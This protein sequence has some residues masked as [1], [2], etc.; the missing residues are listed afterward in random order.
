[1]R[2]QHGSQR[3][4]AR[5]D[6]LGILFHLVLEGISRGE[7]RGVGGKG[8]RDLAI[9]LGEQGALLGERIHVG[10]ADAGIP[11]GAQ[12]V[13]AERVNRYK[14]DGGWLRLAGRGEK[15]KQEGGGC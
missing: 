12:V 6:D 3:D 5:R 9:G 10:S 2:P 1:M 15:Q 11:I 13:S 8:Q 4:R 7:E 14:D